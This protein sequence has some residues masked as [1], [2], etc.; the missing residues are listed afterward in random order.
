MFFL[1][2]LFIFSIVTET[3]FTFVAQFCFIFSCCVVG[4]GEQAEGEGEGRGQEQGEGEAAP[5]REY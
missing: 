1:L 4:H 3:F 5:H 2:L